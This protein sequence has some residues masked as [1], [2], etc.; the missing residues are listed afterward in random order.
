MNLMISILCIYI[1]KINKIESNLISEK[2]DLNK[3]S[4]INVNQKFN[5]MKLFIDKVERILFYIWL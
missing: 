3:K 1:F 4:E 2:M 5:K